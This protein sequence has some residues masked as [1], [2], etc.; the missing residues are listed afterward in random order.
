[1]NPLVEVD[2]ET[3]IR[4][5]I[6]GDEQAFAKLVRRYERQLATLIRYQINDPN[7]AED[8]L[9]E[10]LV[11]AW[12]GIH[13]LREPSRFSVWLLQI[14]RNRCRDFH[15]SIQRRDQ[16]TEYNELEAIVNRFGQARIRQREVVTD[17]VDAFEELAPAERDIAKRFYLEGFTIAEIAARNLC[18]EGTVK[19]HL[20]NARNHLRQ[21]FGIAKRR[22]K[23]SMHQQKSKQQL[24]PTRRP[25][26]VVTA[27]DIEPFSLDCPELKWGS[28]YHPK[29]G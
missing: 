29:A 6:Q 27:I 1:V 5:S 24:F 18:P 20:S 17:V 9:Q 10:T 4:R 8:I 14:A 19:W 3:L 21:I 22:Q 26:I 12:F 15:R 7:Y 23:I 2:E 13:R 16:P 28:I 11:D 25:E